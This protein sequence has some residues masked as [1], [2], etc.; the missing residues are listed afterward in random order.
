MLTRKD[1]EKIVS[2]LT[3]AFEAQGAVLML[4]YQGVD[5]DG[6]VNLRQKIREAGGKMKV[7][8]KTLLK[9]AFAAAN[10]P[11]PDQDVLSGQTGLVYGFDDPV[12]AAKAV[13][14][15]RRELV[16]EVGDPEK[17]TFA[18]RGGILDGN[19][20][21]AADA[22]A[23]ATIPSREE[24]LAKAVGSIA[25]PLRGLVGVLQGPQRALVYALHAIRETK[26]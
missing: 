14:S 10:L 11:E 9:R 25:S 12:A 8:K 13:V 7:V 23:L 19:V 16:E 15:F 22:N 26:A 18:V 20:L 4:D 17:V 24:L 1:K 5:A 21:P 6:M 2:D 3:K